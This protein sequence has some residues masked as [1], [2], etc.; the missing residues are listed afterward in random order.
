MSIWQSLSD[1]ITESSQWVELTQTINSGL[2][3]IAETEVLSNVAAAA[4]NIVDG[5]TRSQGFQQVANVSR[6][7][8]GTADTGY[9]DAGYQEIANIA[10]DAADAV[11]SGLRNAQNTVLQA[12]NDYVNTFETQLRPWELP[13]TA[14]DEARD[15]ANFWQQS[16]NIPGG[17]LTDAEI[18]QFGE[19]MEEIPT[20]IADPRTIVNNMLDQVESEARAEWQSSQWGR[21]RS[22][23]FAR[24]AEQAAETVQRE[25][26][27]RQAAR[28]D[29][30]A[31]RVAQQ[32]QE[33]MIGDRDVSESINRVARRVNAVYTEQWVQNG[34]NRVQMGRYWENSDPNAR[35]HWEN[36][37]QDVSVESDLY[38][39]VTESD[40]IADEVLQL[41]RRA[42]PVMRQIS[43]RMVAGDEGGAIAG[44]EAEYARARVPQWQVDWVGEDVVAVQPEDV[45]EGELEPLVGDMEIVEVELAA[46]EPAEEAAVIAPDI[47]DGINVE[48]EA[49]GVAGVGAVVGL[50]MGA[51]A[52][53]GGV[54]I[55]TID[56][57]ARIRAR[58]DAIFAQQQEEARRN[59]R[60]HTTWSAIYTRW[61][62]YKTPILH[63][64]SMTDS[65][66]RYSMINPRSGLWR[67]IRVTG[68]SMRETKWSQS[69]DSMWRADDWRNQVDNVRLP[70]GVKTW[71][72][73]V[74]PPEEETFHI[75]F[76]GRPQARSLT[77]NNIHLLHPAPLTPSQLA[78]NR[79]TMMRQRAI[80]I[81]NLM[82]EILRHGN[83][84]LTRAMITHT[85]DEPGMGDDEGILR[86][87]MLLAANHGDMPSSLPV[88]MD[89]VAGSEIDRWIRVATHLLHQGADQGATNGWTPGDVCVLFSDSDGV[90]IDTR[91]DHIHIK[92]LRVNPDGNIRG[93]ITLAVENPDNLQLINRNPFAS[94]T[95]VRPRSPVVNLSQTP[96]SIDLSNW[97]EHAIPPPASTDPWLVPHA[98]KKA[99]KARNVVY[100]A[101]PQSE[102]DLLVWGFLVTNHMTV[103]QVLTFVDRLGPFAPRQM[104]LAFQHARERRDRNSQRAGVPSVNLIRMIPDSSEDRTVTQMPRRRLVE[105]SYD[106]DW[107]LRDWC[108]RKLIY[109]CENAKEE[110]DEK[111]EEAP[112]DLFPE[113]EPLLNSIRE[114]TRSRTP[115]EAASNAFE[116]F[117]DICEEATRVTGN[118]SYRVFADDWINNYGRLIH[119]FDVA[120]HVLVSLAKDF[121]DDGM[122]NEEERGHITMDVN[123]YVNVMGRT[124]G[125]RG[126]VN[127]EGMGFI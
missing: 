19:G 70:S 78:W 28:W 13:M 74:W 29:A 106:E 125:T 21:D 46:L 31:A 20:V 14:E 89:H 69:T 45:I 8:L 10:G 58:D 6:E 72:R 98:W 84:A 47:A 17:A 123:S 67:I 99:S 101:I 102:L 7:A 116:Y 39:N 50:A 27:A 23:T 52:I 107:P 85:F 113:G 115:E 56:T 2:A 117:Y 111:T 41:G 51:A 63:R 94:Q 97:D 83:T 119:R 80:L 118:R 90:L 92:T 25:E 32:L 127:L 120:C 81:R 114:A 100:Q 30:A 16:R 1:A 57:P 35:A 38:T 109:D 73:V 88:E 42:D 61:L 104:L 96:I 40:Q 105:D 103:G 126:N 4:T 124:Q 43:L 33:R 68:Y 5:I 82:L 55:H 93:T 95:Y 75:A 15:V 44:A 65:F 112:G 108:V 77:I 66:R 71:G 12:A 24:Y 18:A 76:Q 26:E 36:R 79:A 54:M 34:E 49:A 62:Q 48:A 37:I 86:I 87:Q 53:A 122:F 121:H 64:R 22:G 60:E 59:K 11:S 9:M 110:V 91:V 3:Q